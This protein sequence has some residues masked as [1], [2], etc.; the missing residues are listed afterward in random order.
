MIRAGG[1]THTKKRWRVQCSLSLQG[2]IPITKNVEVVDLF[3]NTYAPTYIRRA[4]GL[5]KSGRARWSDDGATKICLLVSPAQIDEEVNVMDINGNY[6]IPSTSDDSIEAQTQDEN[7]ENNENDENDVKVLYETG[8]A[9]DVKD[10]KIANGLNEAN[11]T[12]VTSGV[13]DVNVIIGASG[14]NGEITLSIGYIL[15]QMEKIRTDN[16]Y[17]MEALNK[18]MDIESHP[19]TMN[20]ADYGA[21]AKAEAIGDIVK[22]REA[23]NQ[24]LLATYGQMYDDIKPKKERPESEKG[25]I[26][27]WAAEMIPGN[28][29]FAEGFGAELGKLLKEMYI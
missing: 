21:Q 2:A 1:E 28:Q 3:G 10:V 19:P 15:G 23:T 7:N 11:N 9:N 17:I 18:I 24:K 5:V 14:V 29:L 4:K 12:K 13:N 26:L 27:Q 25:K 8:D 22:A 20:A 6:N 16:G